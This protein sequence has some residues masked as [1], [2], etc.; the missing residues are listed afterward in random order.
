MINDQEGAPLGTFEDTGTAADLLAA[1]ARS[2]ERFMAVV[3]G[4]PD[5]VAVI[6][7]GRFTLLNQRLVDLLG[8]VRRWYAEQVA[9]SGH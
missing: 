1:F 5:P 6:S 9:R 3:A 4:A 2:E 7:D 8:F